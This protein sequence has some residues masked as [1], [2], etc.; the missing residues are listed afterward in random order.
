MVGWRDVVAWV[1]FS[2]AV[3]KAEDHASSCEE[4]MPC[5]VG[6]GVKSYDNREVFIT[7]VSFGI[8]LAS[9]FLLRI[10]HP[11][12]LPCIS[13]LLSVDSVSRDF[14]YEPSVSQHILPCTHLFWFS[15]G[16]D[17]GSKCSRV[18]SHSR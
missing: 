5:V 18:Y 1:V 13:F 4:R 8:F 15:F 6:R 17:L 3:G 14:S 10:M 2:L 11:L 9:L 12:T 16:L 7:A